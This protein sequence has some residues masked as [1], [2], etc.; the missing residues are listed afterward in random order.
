MI[1]LFCLSMAKGNQ[2]F[3][4]FV[5]CVSDK[6]CV[7][8]GAGG[9]RG[10]GPGLWRVRLGQ[11]R[12][13]V[14]RCEECMGSWTAMVWTTPAQW[15]QCSA[16]QQ[17][18][19]QQILD[20]SHADPQGLAERCVWIMCCGCNCMCLQ[21]MTCSPLLYLLL[22]RYLATTAIFSGQVYRSMCVPF[23]ECLSLCHVVFW[24]V[25]KPVTLGS[26]LLSW[27]RGID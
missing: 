24:Q 12:H 9:H 25:V 7:L 27:A 21:L 16:A 10:Q 1:S 8:A 13:S 11:E 23:I 19:N 14:C 17:W 22:L 15:T 20:A 26:G 3:Q 4:A 2:C 6:G 5:Q 18:Q